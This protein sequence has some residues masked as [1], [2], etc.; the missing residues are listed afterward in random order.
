MARTPAPRSTA[1]VRRE[2]VLQAALEAFASGGLGTPADGIARRAGISQPYLF[3][4]YPTKRDLFIAAIDRCFSTISNVFRAAGADLT[5]E[6]ATE[7]LG[8][9]YTDLLA[10]DPV[11][12]RMQMQAYASSAVDP[13]VRA[14]TLRGYTGVWDTVVTVTGMDDDGARTFFATGMLLNVI[15]ALGLRPDGPEPLVCRLFGPT[16]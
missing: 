12:L 16:P 4:L 15:A 14:A 6:L 13:E 8:Q 10:D 1:D 9:A 3:R 7:A 11:L 5:G 2:D